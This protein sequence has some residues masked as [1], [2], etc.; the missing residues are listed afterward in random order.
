MAGKSPIMSIKHY[1]QDTVS[2]VALGAIVT[3]TP[4]SAVAAPSTSSEVKEGSIVKALYLEYWVTSDDT[5]QGS[6][7]VTVE[8]VPASATTQTYAQSI[9]LHTY[10]NKKNI[11]YTTMGLNNATPGVAMPILKQWV[12]IPRGKQRMG[13]GDKIV[14]NFS[15][16]SNGMNLCGFVTYKEYQ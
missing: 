15:G 14:V 7:V 13:L 1:R 10:P 5:A 3:K 11:L 6:F 4:V 8:K 16:I 2:T 9:A 12:A